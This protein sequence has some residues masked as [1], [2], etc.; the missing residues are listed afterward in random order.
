M[1]CKPHWTE[2]ITSDDLR[3]QF[4]YF[5]LSFPPDYS[6]KSFAHKLVKQSLHDFLNGIKSLSLGVELTRNINEKIEDTKPGTVCVYETDIFENKGGI[7][8]YKNSWERDFFESRK[9]NIVRVIL[10]KSDSIGVIDA[11]LE[12]YRNYRPF[13]DSGMIVLHHVYDEYDEIAKLSAYCRISHFSDLIVGLINSF[14]TESL[15]NVICKAMD[16]MLTKEKIEE[17][18]FGVFITYEN[19]TVGS[20]QNGPC[21]YRRSYAVKEIK[22]M[23]AEQTLMQTARLLGSEICNGI[24]QN[25]EAVVQSKLSDSFSIVYNQIT[26]DIYVQLEET[27]TGV[28]IRIFQT[29]SGYVINI[30][31]FL[32]TIFYPVDVN[33]RHWRGQVAE[34]IFNKT[35]EKRET[36]Y[37]DA[38]KD[39]QNMCQKSTEDFKLFLNRL[40]ESKTR[41]CPNDQRQHI[42]EWL[43]RETIPDTSF[44][45]RYPSIL[46]CIV[47]HRGDKQTVVKIFLRQE[48]KIAERSFK[49]ACSFGISKFEFV[50]LAEKTKEIQEEAQET[51]SL[52]RKIPVD[53]WTRKILKQIIQEHGTK[54]YAKYSNVV[55]MR[56]GGIQKQPCI[57]LYCLDKTLIPY[58]EQPLPKYLAGW[59]C[60][61]R[62]DFVLFGACPNNCQQ[63]AQNLPEAGCSIGMPSDNSSGSVGFL[64]ES[65]SPTQ[66]SKC[67]FITASHVAIKRFQE[68]YDNNSLLSMSP[69]LSLQDHII[70]H[71]SWQDNE[72]VDNAI[73]KVAES[74][75]GNYGLAML[76]LDFAFVK[77]NNCR[78][79]EKEVLAVA[80]DEDLSY[81]GD[82]TVTKLG[83]TTGKTYGDL[84]DNS[85]TVKVDR[86]SRSKQYM[87]FYNCYAIENKSKND[88]F[89]KEGDSGSGVFVN[90][91][92]ESL[93][94]LGIAFAFLLSQTAVCRIDTIVDKLDLKIV[95]YIENRT[96]KSLPLE[97]TITVHTIPEKMD[98]DD[99]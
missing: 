28:L 70:V 57:V 73:G 62:E 16:K 26:D 86:S 53:R 65:N 38:V 87:T 15:G 85:L 93:K 7:I 37:S 31:Q 14:S 24:L 47:G 92:D 80:K 25:I 66:I 17:L 52:E 89:F 72:H 48:D 6:G 64:V 76:G 97:K 5:V 30:M 27:I 46:K 69:N 74:F 77:N 44:F 94:P 79:E 78:N 11:K 10:I 43:K 49:S 60:D 42:K 82:V 96:K 68:L 20:V 13:I 35:S 98:V 83:R 32:M 8:Q 88:F 51:K 1:D 58:G 33:S 2:P 54:I 61:I 90:G 22:K 81:E 55:G 84:T 9:E 67:G 41:F 63:Y 59:P 99:N 71:P 23:L 75:C 40:K 29:L 56:I 91:K 36:I 39:I 21:F 12:A 45:E 50:N 95:K 3:S 18:C 19:E 4:S 34:E